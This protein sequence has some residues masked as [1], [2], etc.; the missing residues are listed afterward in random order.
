MKVK[1]LLKEICVALI[2]EL[3]FQLLVVI[4]LSIGGIAYFGYML[5]GFGIIFLLLP[6]LV[7]IYK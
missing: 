5:L 4:A 3:P 6:Y 7:T 2:Y 1:K